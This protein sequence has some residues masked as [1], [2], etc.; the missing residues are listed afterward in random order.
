MHSPK[1]PEPPALVT[2]PPPPPMLQ[3]PQGGQAAL[4]AKKRA[5]AASGYGSTIISGP[6]GDT[7]AVQTSAKTLTGQ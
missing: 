5:L 7:R 6:Q 3:S 2:P 4:D 1:A